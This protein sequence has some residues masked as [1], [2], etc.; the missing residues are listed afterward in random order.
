MNRVNDPDGDLNRQFT[1]QIMARYR[2]GESL[3]SLLP[4]LIR[5]T[6]PEHGCINLEKPDY[7]GKCIHPW[8]I[9]GNRL[10]QDGRYRDAENLYHELIRLMREH[11]RARHPLLGLAYNDLALVY[12]AQNSPFQAARAFLNAIQWDFKTSGRDALRFPALENLRKML[13][14]LASVERRNRERK[15]AAL[16]ATGPRRLRAPAVDESAEPS[17]Q[18][19]FVVSA[20]FLFLGAAWLFLGAWVFRLEVLLL[21]LGAVVFIAMGAMAK[22]GPIGWFE[23]SREGL[24]LIAKEMTTAGKT[25]LRDDI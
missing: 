11:D 18:T 15:L 13:D 1:A 14:H 4:D 12:V 22:M 3:A 10:R 20:T 19:I 7:P 8:D 9:L 6:D 21:L 5:Q 25:E 17:P 16:L 23:L 2:S 24:K